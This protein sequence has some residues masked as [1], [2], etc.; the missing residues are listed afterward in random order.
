MEHGER[1][2]AGEPEQARQGVEGQDDP[3]V[4]EAAVGV[5]LVLDMAAAAACK[6]GVEEEVGEDEEGEG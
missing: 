4:E 6:D 1:D 3:F 2:E 5:L